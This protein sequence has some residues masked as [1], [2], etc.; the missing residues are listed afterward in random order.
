MA[1]ERDQ[2]GLKLTI[3]GATRGTGKLLVDQALE[4]GYHV[5]A[6]VRDPSKLAETHERLTIIRGELRDQEGIERAVSG[7]NAV[8]SV[9]GPRGDSKGK[10]ITEGIQNIIAAMRGRRRAPIDH[11]LNSKC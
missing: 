9:L 10:P 8:I 4:A 11:F 3:F 1:E 6:Y 7:A 5:V 2:K